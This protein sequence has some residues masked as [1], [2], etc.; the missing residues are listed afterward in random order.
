MI[1]VNLSNNGGIS[2]VIN[3]TG[4]ATAPGVV[5]STPKVTDFP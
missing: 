4:D 1:T 2:H 3:N 5:A